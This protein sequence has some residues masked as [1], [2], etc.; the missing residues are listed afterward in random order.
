MIAVHRRN[1]ACGDSMSVM[2]WKPVAIQV[3]E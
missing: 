1:P 2:Q 3:K